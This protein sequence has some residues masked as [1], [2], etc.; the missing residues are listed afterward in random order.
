MRPYRE[1]KRE[2]AIA[3]ADGVQAETVPARGLPTAMIDID[4]IS[5]FADLRPSR[6]S[7]LSGVSLTIGDG[8]IVPILGR[9]GCGKSTLLDIASDLVSPQVTSR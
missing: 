4:C 6:P 7:A 1:E 5:Q 3:M 2:I 8:A 9:S